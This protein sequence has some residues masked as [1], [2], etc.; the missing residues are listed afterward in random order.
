MGGDGQKHSEC[1]QVSL[2]ESGRRHVVCLMIARGRW[3]G[4]KRKGSGGSGRGCVSYDTKATPKIESLESP[5]IPAPS[6]A[7][8]SCRARILVN[9]GPGQTAAV[10]STRGLTMG[11][12]VRW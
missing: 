3:D 6:P 2:R 4:G 11:R 10:A 1:A 5:P 7:P 12:T 8:Q 9:V